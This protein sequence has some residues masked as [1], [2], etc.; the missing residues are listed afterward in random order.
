MS[1]NSN[2]EDEDDLL[3]TPEEDLN[4]KI[5]KQNMGLL[6][7]ENVRR[8]YFWATQFIGLLIVCLTLVHIIQHKNGFGG[9]SYP[10]LEFNWHYI[11]MMLGF[12]YFFANALT[13]FRLMPLLSKQKLKYIH[14]GTNGAV[15]FCA[16]LGLFFVIDERDI[17]GKAHFQS[18]HSWIGIF[19][20]GLLV[21]QFILGSVFYLSPKI[22]LSYKEAMMPWH[23]KIGISAF[24][25]GIGAIITGLKK[26]S[27]DSERLL[28]NFTGAFVIIYCFFILHVLNDTK[29]KF[30]YRLR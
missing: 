20:I 9:R 6:S 10:K 2:G 13:V 25:L 8:Y 21:V 19:T 23:V 16:A 18:L 1:I 3:L 26:G 28:I 12:T 11:F 22:S 14:L 27:S 7:V 5:S 4:L 15:I 17:L 30:N 24:I 29:Y